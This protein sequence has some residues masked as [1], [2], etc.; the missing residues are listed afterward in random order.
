LIKKYKYAHD[1]TLLSVHSSSV[2]RQQLGKQFSA[3]KN[4]H[5]VIDRRL[6]FYSD[7]ATEEWC[8][9]CSLCRDVIG[10]TISVSAISAVQLSEVKRSNMLVS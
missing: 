1:I 10:R 4:A 2:A 6:V 5:E 3:A 7:T 9:L 8:F